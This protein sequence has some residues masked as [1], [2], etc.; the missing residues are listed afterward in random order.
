MNLKELHSVYFMGIGGIGMSAI[1]R[2]FNHIGIPVYG[3]DK[4][5][6]PLTGLLEQEGMQISY[7]DEVDTLPEALRTQKEDVL[8]V[9]TPAIPKDSQLLGYF[10]SAG[11]E[12]K[13]R[14]EVLGMITASMY[15][16]AVAGTHGKTTTSSMVAHLLKHAGKNVVAFLGGLTQTYESNLILSEDKGEGKPTA[17]VEADEFDRA[18]LRLHPDVAVVTIVD[19]DHLD[20]YGDA[21]HLKEGFTEF[22]KL[23]DAK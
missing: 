5:P 14:S 23:V 16:V 21:E 10:R 6:S 13:K 2:W 4:T 18:I 8:V 12:L 19:R 1:A 7:V 17:V 20:I 11:F 3:Y 15:A 9:W 22:I